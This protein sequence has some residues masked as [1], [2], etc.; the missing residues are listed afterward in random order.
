MTKGIELTLKLSTDM[1]STSR[2][3]FVETLPPGF[4]TQNTKKRFWQPRSIPGKEE[5]VRNERRG[6]LFIEKVHHQLPD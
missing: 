2:K 4:L 3:L 5:G 1:I 6:G